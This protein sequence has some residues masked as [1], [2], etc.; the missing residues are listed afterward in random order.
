MFCA[1]S[2]AVLQTIAEGTSGATP[3]TR[4]PLA[5][6]GIDRMLVDA[7]LSLRQRLELVAGWRDNRA[8]SFDRARLK[9]HLADTFRRERKTIE[10]I[11]SS[12]LQSHDVTAFEA[13]SARLAP[14]FADWRTATGS[15][16]ETD[17]GLLLGSLCHMHVNRMLQMDHNRQELVLYDLLSQFYKGQLA[18]TAQS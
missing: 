11:L 3:E 15:R 16:R 18:R 14:A 10:S 8:R 5:L 4:W 6:V 13:R 9:R 17:I 2:E 12:D 1:D 7:G